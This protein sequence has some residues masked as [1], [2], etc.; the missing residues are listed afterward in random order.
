M[1]IGHMK[2]KQSNENLS[3]FL[4]NHY[5]QTLSETLK[6][7]FEHMRVTIFLIFGTGWCEFF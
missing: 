6:L 7:K 4:T 2:F 1:P 5:H 3:E